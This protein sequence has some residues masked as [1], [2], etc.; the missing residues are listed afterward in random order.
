MDEKYLSPAA[1]AEYL[2][3][4]RPMLYKHVK[5]GRLTKYQMEGN[6]KLVFFSK[7][8]LTKLKEAKDQPRF[9]AVPKMYPHTVLS[10]VGA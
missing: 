3:V 7:E 9:I 6:D 5:A 10:P 1:A 8:E 4:Q 2:G